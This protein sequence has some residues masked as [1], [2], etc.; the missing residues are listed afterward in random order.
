MRFSNN[1]DNTT[2]V[3]NCTLLRFYLLLVAFVSAAVETPTYEVIQT[4]EDYE[5][6]RYD[7]KKWVA[8]SLDA[9]GFEEI[10]GDLFNTLFSYIDGGNEEGIVIPMT[11]P[12]TTLVLPGEG[13]NCKQTFTCAFYIPDDLQANPPIPT[14]PAVFI[15]ERPEFE[16][17]S[18]QFSGYAY[19][20]DYISEGY[21]LY[22]SLERDNVTDA[23]YAPW[24]IVG[25]NSPFDFV[26]RRN[27]V[28]FSRVAATKKN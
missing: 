4:G 17:Y 6:R 14:N 1:F 28:W 10:R 26:D 15:E 25:Y 7:P 2:P 12:V 27:E 19:E 9:F 8:T 3:I 11:A 16:L 24:Y 18:R 22:Q 21:A 13:P 23:Q 5:V 20:A